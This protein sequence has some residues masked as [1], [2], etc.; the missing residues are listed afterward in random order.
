MNLQIWSPRSSEREGLVVLLPHLAARAEV[1]WVSEER[2]P[3]GVPWVPAAAAPAMDPSLYDVA[4]AAE[5]AFAFRA[6]RERP[7]VVLLRD[8][9]FPVLLAGE[10]ARPETRAAALREMQR[11]FGEDGAFVARMVARGLGGDVLPALF[12]LNDR[13]L[14]GSLGI[15]ALTE[16]TRAGAGRRLGDARTLRLPLYL[17]APV[18]VPSARDARQELGLPESALVVATGVH[19]LVR[20]PALA[21]VVAE[22]RGEFPDLRLL[23]GR[24]R[25]ALPP[26]ALAVSDLGTMAAAADVFVALDPLTP[27]GVPAGLSEALAARRPLVLT[28]GSSVTAD[29]P[30]GTVAVVEPGRH[31]E[32]ELQGVLRHLLRHPDLRARLGRLAAEEARRVA[33]PAALA[34]AL[35]RFLLRLDSEKEAILQARRDARAREETLLGFLTQ[36]VRGDARSL[37]LHSSDLGLEPLLE[38]LVRAPR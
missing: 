14:E 16:E 31:E 1:L 29:L 26:G 4:D 34:E 13:L 32:G 36:E 3:V 23:V 30:E 19:D 37:G 17:L 24:G 6:A 33:D 28:A 10:M 11:A 7:G 21:R 27:G 8:W 9:S 20:L 18:G 15:V 35:A 25:V 12:P 2:A 5:H 38:S 22:L